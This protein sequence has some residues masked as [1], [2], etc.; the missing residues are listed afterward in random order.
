MN[1]PGMIMLHVR[2]ET[3]ADLGYSVY[4]RELTVGNCG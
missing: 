2:T 3:N 1:Y 4:P